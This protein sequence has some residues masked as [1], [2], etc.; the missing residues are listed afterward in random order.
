MEKKIVNAGGRLSHSRNF[1]FNHPQ[2]TSGDAKADWIVIC[3]VLPNTKGE[4]KK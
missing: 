3:G 4:S 1:R 2:T